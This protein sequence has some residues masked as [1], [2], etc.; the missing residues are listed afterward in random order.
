MNTRLVK[1]ESHWVKNDIIPSGQ[2][3]LWSDLSLVLVPYHYNLFPQ[4]YTVCEAWTKYGQVQRKKNEQI[5]SDGETDTRQNVHKK[6]NKQ[7]SMNQWVFFFSSSSSEIS[8]L[9]Y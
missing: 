4:G 5:I 9:L 6:Q 3:P 8:N 7:Y 2:V 1:H